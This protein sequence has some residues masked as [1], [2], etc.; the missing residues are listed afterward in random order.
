MTMAEIIKKY[1][2][3]WSKP[4]YA[5]DDAE[6]YPLKTVCT[7]SESGLDRTQINPKA[8]DLPESLLEF[9][10]ICDSARLFVDVDYGQWGLEILNYEDAIKETEDQFEERPNEYIEGDLVIGKFLGDC[11]LLVIRCD[12]KA[13]DYGQII[14]ALPIDERCDWFFLSVTYQAFLEKYLLEQ[15]EKYWEVEERA[16]L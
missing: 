11:D 3:E 6:Q 4:H 10:D 15:G 2:A 13:N 16:N 9:W 1:K 7:F 12:K 8:I 14:V 5:F